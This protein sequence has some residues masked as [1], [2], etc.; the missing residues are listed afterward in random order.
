[1]DFQTNFRLGKKLT[2]SLYRHSLE[3]IKPA[4]TSRN[5]LLRHDIAYIILSD[6]MHF[7]VGEFAPIHGLSLDQIGWIDELVD[8]WNNC[9]NN[10]DWEY[11]RGRSSAFAFALETALLHYK[12]CLNE[13]I[14]PIPINGLVWMNDLDNMYAESIEKIKAGF[15]CI[16]LKIGAHDFQDEL[17]LIANLRQQ[18]GP[19]QII[20][21][22]DANGAFDPDLALEKLT[23]LAEFNIHSI[24]QPI[25]AGQ[26]IKMAELCAKSPIPIALDEE[27]IGHYSTAEKEALL[28]SI[29]PQYIILKPTLHGGLQN[30]DEWI[31]IAESMDI[32]W[33]A[34]SA[35]ESN[36]GLHAIA[37][38]LQ[39]KSYSG[40]Q[41]L[42]TGALYSNNIPSPI[43]VEKGLLKWD[44]NG[45][46]DFEFLL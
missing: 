8:D 26:W 21:R 9:S 46:W 19:D 6:G 2:C 30:A 37:Q 31:K 40:Y 18:F 11:W 20:L 7:G 3:F 23:A 27:L 1:M 15:R 36:V 33:W 32:G 39:H 17:N 28:Q 5:T 16:K 4:K 25:R 13:A 14:Q 12:G 45:S 10:W 22:L 35:L 43:K 24:E 38:W 44:A 42:G 34:T 41:G 29:R